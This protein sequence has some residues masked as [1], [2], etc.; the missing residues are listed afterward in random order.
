MSLKF[1]WN[2]AVSKLNGEQIEDLAKVRGYRPEFIQWFSNQGF[3]A[4]SPFRGGRW[5]FPVKRDGKIVAAHLISFDSL[6]NFLESKAT[7]GI[8]TPQNDKPTENR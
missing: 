2:S 3:I 6:R 4:W 7:G 8:E 5:C 1:D